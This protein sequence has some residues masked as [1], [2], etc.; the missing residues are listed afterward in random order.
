MNDICFSI[1]GKCNETSDG[2]FQ[3]ICD[4]GWQGINCESMVNYC[5][6]EN[7]T[8]MNNGICLP[9]LLNYTCE[10][11]GDNFYSGRHCEIT[12]TKILVH[13]TISKSFAYIAIIAI[14]TVAMF[15]VIMDILKY[16]FGVDPVREQREKIHRAKPVIKRKR[17]VV[18]RFIYVNAPPV[19]PPSGNPTATVIETV[20]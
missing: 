1:L 16:C 20:V 17:P 2:T 19:Q 8:C 18:Q 6:Y 5:D 13:E 11:L 7:V 15:V 9:L 3:C 12:S 14:T 4:D 10:C